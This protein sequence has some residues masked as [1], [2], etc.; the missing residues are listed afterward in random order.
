MNKERRN[1]CK[2]CLV[3]E[4]IHY[5]NGALPAVDWTFTKMC[6]KFVPRAVTLSDIREALHKID[7]FEHIVR[8]KYPWGFVDFDGSGK[9]LNIGFNE[10][11]SLEVRRIFFSN[12]RPDEKNG[13][14]IKFDGVSIFV[15]GLQ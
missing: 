9:P 14:I 7:H 4:E 2:N 1:Q 5:P 3:D 13:K 12:F 6:K 10:K 15:E 11:V 8:C